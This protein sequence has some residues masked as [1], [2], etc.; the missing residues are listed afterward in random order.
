[1]SDQGVRIERFDVDLMHRQPGGTPDQP[2]HQQP[3]APLAPLRVT[4]SPRPP[5]QPA[6]IARPSPAAASAGGLN[7]IV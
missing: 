7:V 2:G 3:E 6:P 5:S 4:P 1:L